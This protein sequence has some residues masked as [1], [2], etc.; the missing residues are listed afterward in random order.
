M[1]KFPGW[2]DRDAVRDAA[3]ELW[4]KLPTEKDPAKA[5]RVLE[6]LITNPLMKRVWGE[7]YKEKRINNKPTGQYEYPACVTNA[8]IAAR[9]RRRAI[10]LRNK[11]G[12]WDE[13]DAQALEFEA[14][15]VERLEDP[16]ADQKWSEQDRAVQL[17]LRHAYRD[18]LDLKP[19]FLSD[20]K[21]KVE[22]LRDVGEILRKQ[23][24]T[25]RSLGKDL[26]AQKLNEIA[27]ECDYDAGNVLPRFDGDDPWIITRQNKEHE[28][29]TFVIDLSGTTIRLFEK[30]MHS[31]LANV[32]NVVFNRKDVTRSKIREML[33]HSLR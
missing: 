5:Q 16:P 10:E 17:F 27:S 1:P 26:D 31:T 11:A 12:Q 7:L 15:I 25:L 30:E 22:K 24:A 14:A 21:A 18:W 9:L 8:S 32:A 33:R 29:R 20:L 6:Q 23:A 13:R 19:V 28:L 4:S 3:S 2:L